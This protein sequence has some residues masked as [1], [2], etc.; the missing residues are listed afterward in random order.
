MYFL[1]KKNCWKFFFL[2]FLLL[3]L[4]VFRID[5]IPTGKLWKPW[6]FIKILYLAS[7]YWNHG[8]FYMTWVS[9]S[10]CFKGAFPGLRQ[11]L[12]TESPLKMMKNNFISPQKLFSFSRYLNICLDVLV[13][14]KNGLI[15]KMRLIWNLWRHSL[16]TTWLTNN[17]NTHITQ[18]LKK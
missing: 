1:F 7:S 6:P 8:H 5:E 15:R 3:L 10:P 14:N 11:F 12:A 16:V 2:F 4:C 9:R 17:S 18:Y 13:M